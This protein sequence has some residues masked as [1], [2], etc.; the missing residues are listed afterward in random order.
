MRKVRLFIA[1]SLDGYIARLDGSVDWLFHDSDYGFGRFSSSIDT[2]IMG[3]K[4]YEK[5][6][7][8][9]DDSFKKKDW[10]VFARKAPEYTEGRIFF[11]SDPVGTVRRLRKKKGGGIWLVG[12]SEIIQVLLQAG[13][14]DEMI[15]FIHPIL[16][17]GGIPL[18]RRTGKEIRLGMP[19]VRRYR[20]GLVRLGY[21]IRDGG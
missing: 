19:E 11:S 18:F 1:S 21:R 3:R 13:L 2:M 15:I 4:T 17:G 8:L 6:L 9:G 20:S 12:G 14:I 7:E 10:V 5:A 16:L